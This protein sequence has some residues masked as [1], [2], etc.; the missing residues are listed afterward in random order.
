MTLLGEEELLAC[1]AAR[2]FDQ[3]FK[4]AALERIEAGENISALIAWASRRLV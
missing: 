1:D 4:M 3:A 2:R